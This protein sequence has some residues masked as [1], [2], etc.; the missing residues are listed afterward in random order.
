VLRQAQ[1]DTLAAYRAG[2]PVLV[3]SDTI[4]AGPRLHDEMALL[5]AAGLTPAEVLRAATLDAA[6]FMGMEHDFGSVAVGKQ[7]DMV[8]LTANPLADIRMTRRIEGVML[9]GHWHAPE[10]LKA[11]VRDQAGHPG[12]WARMLWGFLTSPA[13]G[14]L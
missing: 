12:N 13:S 10:P 3:G 2:V 4:I 5:V 6:H 1:A 7:A 14:S 9:N 8:L 11:Y